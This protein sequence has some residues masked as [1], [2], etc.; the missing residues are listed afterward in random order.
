MY[1]ASH[2][3][4]RAQIDHVRKTLKSLTDGDKPLIEV[5]NKCDLIEPGQLPNDTMTVSATKTTGKIFFFLPSPSILVY[6]SSYCMI[7][8]FSL[9]FR[10]GFTASRGSAINSL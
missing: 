8:M 5:A 2:P 7:E 9:D 4:K 3:D 10:I 1:D 6:S